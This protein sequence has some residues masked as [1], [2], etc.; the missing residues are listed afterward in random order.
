MGMILLD[1][2]ALI[3]YLQGDKYCATVIDRLR[4]KEKDIG[5]STI[6]E[7]EIFSFP[8]LSGVEML[9]I[10]V[11]I[12]NIQI[13]PVDSVIAREAARVRRKYR[14]LTPDA[15]IAATA[16]VYGVPVVSRDKGLNKVTDIEIIPC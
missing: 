11:W 12:E 15:I 7:T 9:K 6:T 16:I 13:I 10:S 4:R 8:E 1:T 5:I 3:Y 14:L 2:N